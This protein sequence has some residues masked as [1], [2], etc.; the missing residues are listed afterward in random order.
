MCILYIITSWDLTVKYFGKDHTDW[1]YSINIDLLL[2]KMMITYQLNLI[3]TG[4]GSSLLQTAYA[5]IVQYITE[6]HDYIPVYSP[7]S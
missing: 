7:S 1:K 5:Y 4:K 2:V 3:L 6:Y